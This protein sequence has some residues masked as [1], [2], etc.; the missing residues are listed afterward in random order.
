MSFWQRRKFA[1]VDRELADHIERMIAAMAPAL[2]AAF[3]EP[4]KVLREE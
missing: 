3:L 4:I 2:R 1:F